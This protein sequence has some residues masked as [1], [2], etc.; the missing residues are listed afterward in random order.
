MKKHT[1]NDT[2][3]RLRWNG[4]R[5]EKEEKNLG[6]AF[7]AVGA[8]DELDVTAAVLVATTIP[9]LESLQIRDRD[10]RERLEQ[11]MKQVGMEEGDEELRIGREIWPLLRKRSE[12]FGVAGSEYQLGFM[13]QER[14]RYVSAKSS[15]MSKNALFIHATVP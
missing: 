7:A 8:A 14:E 5:K 10:K 12:A 11:W 2:V 15:L 1:Q 13:P 3:Y 6:A 9:A 4:K